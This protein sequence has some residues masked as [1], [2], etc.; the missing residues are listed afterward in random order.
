MSEVLG[1]SPK[2]NYSYVEIQKNSTRKVSAMQRQLDEVTAQQAAAAQEI[3]QNQLLT[4]QQEQIAEIQ[5]ELAVLR[6]STMCEKPPCNET[7]DICVKCM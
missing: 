4:M 1:F 6:N 7:A 2:K 3:A 5:W